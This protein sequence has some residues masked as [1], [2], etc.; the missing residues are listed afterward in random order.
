MPFTDEDQRE[1][2]RLYEGVVTL[3]IELVIGVEGVRRYLFV[4]HDGLEFDSERRARNQRRKGSE[5]EV[6][7]VMLQSL[8]NPMA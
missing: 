7:N 3:A 2:E 6:R 8:P 1:A 4:K 5:V